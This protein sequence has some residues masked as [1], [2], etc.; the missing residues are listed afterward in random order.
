MIDRIYLFS[1]QGNN[2]CGKGAKLV[3]KILKC[4]TTLER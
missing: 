2:L 1:I 3:G 4:N